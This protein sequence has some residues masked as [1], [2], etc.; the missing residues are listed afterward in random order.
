MLAEVLGKVATSYMTVTFTDIGGNEVCRI[1][2]KPAGAPIF[3]RGQK[4]DG[5]FYVRL[6]NS[7]RLLT[8]ADALDYVRSHW[9]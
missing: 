1:D 6:N 2:V 9:R 8:T 5:D 7:T 3:M 4:T